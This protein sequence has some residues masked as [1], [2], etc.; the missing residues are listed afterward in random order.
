MP[1]RSTQIT[2]RGNITTTTTTTTTTTGWAI[3]V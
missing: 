2:Y 3:Y 1:E